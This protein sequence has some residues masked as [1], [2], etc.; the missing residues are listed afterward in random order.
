VNG[1]QTT[2]LRTTIFFVLL[3]NEFADSHFL[4]IFQIV[5]HAHSVV[6]SIS[7]VNTIDLLAWI[8]TAFKTKDGIVS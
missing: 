1:D 3:R 6:I 7:I 2:A 8:L 5:F 4:N